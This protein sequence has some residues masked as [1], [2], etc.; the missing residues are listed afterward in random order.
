MRES[1]KAVP[2]DGVIFLRIW[3]ILVWEAK[4]KPN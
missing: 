4:L 2:P 1:L 3:G